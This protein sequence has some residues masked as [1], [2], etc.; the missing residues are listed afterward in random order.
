MTLANVVAASMFAGITLYALLAGA[1][2]GA[3]FWDLVAGND[4]RGAPTRALIEES[5]GPVWEA[6]HVWLIFVLVT[7]WTGFPSAF[8]PIMSTLYVPLTLAAVGIILRGAAFAFRKASRTLNARRVYGI[9]FASSS[10]ITPYFLGSVV[11]GVASG[12]VPAG[13]RPGGV[14]RSWL[15]PTSVL[16]GVMAVI[17]CA[18]LAAVYLAADADRRNKPELAVLFRR[19]S[20]VAGIAGGVV[21]AVGVAVLHADSPDLFHGLTHRGAPLIVASGVAGAMTLVLVARHRF[22]IARYVAALAVVAVLWGWAAGQYPWMLEHELTIKAAAA[23]RATLE[24]GLLA[25]GV[26]SLLL[27]PA[28]VWLL[29]LFQRGALASEA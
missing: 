29:V 6:N 9:A 7:L 28:L 18:F 10:V 8:A 2:F 17:V 23:P 14:F 1:D 4:E 3:G 19:R 22:A 5:I 12:R 27:V 25:L 16:G 26:G 15:N 24:A 11:G 13:T 20:L 21:A